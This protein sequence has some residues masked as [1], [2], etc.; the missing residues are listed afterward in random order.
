[1]QRD[2]LGLP[3]KLTQ[4]NNSDDKQIKIFSGRANPLLTKEIAKELGLELGQIN[5]KPFADGELY[6]QIQESVRGCDVFLVQPTHSPV[7][8]NLVEML[9]VI[10]AL[11][12]ASAKTIN[13]VM[14]YYGYARQDRK[15]AGREPITAKLVAKMIKEAGADRVLCL[16]LHSEQIIGFFDTLVDHVHAAPVVIDYIKR[17]IGLEN[18]VI[19]SPD[20]GGVSRARAYAKK[21]NDAPIAI[22]D[23]RRMHDQQNVVEVMNVIGDIDGKIAILID[24]LIDTAGTMCKAAQLIKDKGASKV[25]ACATHGVLSGPA[26]ERIQASPIEELIITD[27]IPLAPIWIQSKKVK[28]I[29]VAPFLAEAIRRIYTGDSVSGL[30]V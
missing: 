11:K 12:R 23:K 4:L 24:D 29:S 3:E 17:F 2:L 20:V 10:D 6:V 18:L 19:V 14:P 26:Y 7:N 13:V 8:E 28:Q 25:F 9:I 22:V 21:L 16:D 27:T 1:M 5:I 15:A 30:F